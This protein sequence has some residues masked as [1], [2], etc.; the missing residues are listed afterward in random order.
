[1]QFTG[2]L[3]AKGVE[4]TLM[5]TYNKFA[6]HNEVG[7]SPDFFGYETETFHELMQYRNEH[8]PL[9]MN[10]S[11]THDTKRGEDVRARLNVVTDLHEEWISLVKKWME[12]NKS[13]K[14]NGTPDNNDEY[15]I[16]QTLIGSHPIISPSGIDA[17]EINN[18]PGRLEEYL[19]KALREAKIHSDW[20]AP[21]I[22]YEKAVVEF[23]HNIIENNS[24]FTKSFYPFLKK[25]T[26]YGMINSFGQM[27][28]KFTC[29]G[30]PDVYQGTELWDLSLVDPDNRRPVD[31]AGREI[32]IDQEF[33]LKQLWKTRWNGQIKLLLMQKLLMIRNEFNHVFSDG[34]YH[35]VKI[36]GKY[37][38][39]AIAFI[40]KSGNTFLLSVVPLNFAGIS[41]YVELS[42]DIPHADWQDTKI[43]LPPGVATEWK[44]LLNGN[45][46]EGRGEISL[47]EIFKEFPLGL[48][49]NN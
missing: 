3:M 29:P 48:L 32:K 38:R 16:Y 1:M 7:D 17:D 9:S 11:S 45:D 23:T 26:D 4:D 30:V 42:E 31:Y 20:A 39:D 44:D 47:K 19:Q 49:V 6:G 33:N 35:A 10:G 2:P 36:E 5:Y 41:K 27:L 43:I 12:E 25:V 13:L 40:R 34:E 14:K 18:Y 24:A 15:F 8:W 21:N 37:N 22:E 46:V 28:L